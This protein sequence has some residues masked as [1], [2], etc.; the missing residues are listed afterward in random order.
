MAIKSTIFKAELNVADIDRN[1]Y[2]SHALTVARHPSETD[3]R[4]MVRVLAFALNANEY[5]EFGKGL[6]SDDEPALWRKDFTGA[7]IDWIEVG[8]PDEKWLR[9]ACGRATRVQ[10]YAYG[11]TQNVN[12]WWAQQEKFLARFDNLT[13]YSVPF[14][15][16]KALAKMAE[17]SMSFSASIQDGVTMFS[18]D[19][20][21]VAVELAVLKTGQ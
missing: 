4:M 1:Y 12:V 16:T 15:V 11:G 7:I 14:E 6:S 10:L 13:A 3:E 20:E 9:K 19:A 5:L 17:R 18:N 21:T 8:L 2:A